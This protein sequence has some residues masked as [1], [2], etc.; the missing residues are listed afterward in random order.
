MKSLLLMSM[1]AILLLS[2]SA[3]QDYNSEIESSS[4][5]QTNEKAI[6]ALNT[7]NPFEETGINFF[8]DFDF[9]V[10]KNGYPTSN[11]QLINQV[12]FLIDKRVNNKQSG[13]SI[14]TITPELILLILANPEEK[15]VEIIDNSDLSIA[16]KV[17]LNSFIADLI[18]KQQD[19][20]D[21]VYDHIVTFESAIVVDSLLEED[22]KDTILKVSSISRYSLY[23]EARKRDPDW[24]TSV[25]NRPSGE[26]LKKNQ[27][28]FINLAVLLNV[29]K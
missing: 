12:L 25:T 21:E 26:F 11:E 7:L 14:I 17:N 28:T 22:E 29:L 2:C 24:Q 27:M 5:P 20:Y 19:D 8:N 18:S 4:A 3:D 10:S 23:A 1:T 6:Y 13:K 9:Y 16:V 15:L